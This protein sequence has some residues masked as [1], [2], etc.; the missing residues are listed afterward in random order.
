MTEPAAPAGFPDEVPG[1]FTRAE[2]EL[3]SDS[4]R[5]RQVL[6]LGRYHGRSTLVAAHTARRVVSIDRDSAAPAD[7]WLQRY[8]VRHKVWLR[9]GTFAEL[10]PTSGGPFEACLIDGAHDRASV[11]A[12]CAAAL[13][14]LAPGALVG[15][16]DYD[17]PAHPDVRPVAD[18]L[19]GCLGW[20][21]TGRADFLAV[22]ATVGAS[23]P[24]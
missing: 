5:G 20:Q 2:C 9:E 22:F 21:L 14:H 6:E 24:M 11:E 1:W 18:G 12:D 15:F 13:P 10:V 4:C 19:A 17:D 16:H 7:L 23:H 8:G 3:W